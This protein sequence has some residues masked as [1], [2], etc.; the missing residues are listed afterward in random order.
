MTTIEANIDAD[1]QAQA[2][3]VLAEIGLTISDAVRSMLIQ[4]A[5][6]KELPFNPLIPNAATIAAMEDARRGNLRSFATVQE[7]MDDLNADYDDEE[8]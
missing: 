6:N 4:T 8:D 2:S 3:A 1:I 5:R 7:L